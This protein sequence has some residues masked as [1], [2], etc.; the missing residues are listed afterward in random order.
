MKF[1]VSAAATLSLPDGT[2]FELTKGIVDDSS[3]PDAVKSHWAFPSY[4]KPLDATDLAKE[5]A[6]LD[7]KSQVKNLQASVDD[8]TAQLAAKTAESDGKDATIADLT[9]QLAALNSTA[10][11][12]EQVETKNAKKQSSSDK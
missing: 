6:A 1:I 3:F 12:T 7:L 2:K 5:Q 4:A 10:D 11:A 9:A 8:L